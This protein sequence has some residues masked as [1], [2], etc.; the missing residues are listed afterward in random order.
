ME[1]KSR[2]AEIKSTFD[3]GLQAQNVGDLSAAEQSYRKTLSLQPEHPE[4]NHNIGII[5]V[6]KNQL[7]KAL[8]FF[9]LALESGPNVSL[10]WAS[11]IE[12]LIG[13]DRIDIIRQ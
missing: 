5:F 8:K 9:K 2:L 11:Y 13:L 3:E 6:A 10:F 1:E 12:T 4:A 7:S